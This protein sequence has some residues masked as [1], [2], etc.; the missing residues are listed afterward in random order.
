MCGRPGRKK[1]RRCGRWEST[2]KSH[3][4]KHRA[5]ESLTRWIDVD[6]ASPGDRA[7]VRSRYVAKEYATGAKDDIFAPTPALEGVKAILS[8]MAMSGEG[9]VPTDRLM[10]MAI[11]RAFL[12]APAVREVYVELPEEDK[13]QGK[14]MVGRLEKSLYGTRDAPLSWQ[15]FI[16]EVLCQLGFQRGITQPCILY[17]PTRRLRMAFHVDD[18]IVSGPRRQLDWLKHEID[19]RFE[20][21]S[22]VLGP[23]RDEER[24]V[25][26]LNRT[27]VWHPWGLTYE[28]DE[29][30]AQT[31]VDEMGLRR[32]AG[33]LAGPRRHVHDH[34]Y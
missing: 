13:E 5:S 8:L 27:I 21:T 33:V 6:K 2:R 17:H 22:K 3:E 31:V 29:R 11:K 32:A 20:N 18:F 34:A 1:W 12:H 16:S 26:Y 23:G 15:V 7:D 28:C 9:Y 30:H 19:R 25:T 24:M 4:Q 14:D 10:V